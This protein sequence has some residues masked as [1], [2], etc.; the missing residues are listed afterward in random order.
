[1]FISEYG[2]K[3]RHKENIDGTPKALAGLGAGSK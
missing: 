3:N 1:M 2:I